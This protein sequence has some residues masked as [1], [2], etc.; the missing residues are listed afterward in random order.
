MDVVHWAII[1][2]QLLG[3]WAVIRAAAELARWAGPSAIEDRLY[4]RGKNGWQE[5]CE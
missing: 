1:P 2:N 5:T 3:G 4:S